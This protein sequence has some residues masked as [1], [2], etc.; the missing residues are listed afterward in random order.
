VDLVGVKWASAGVIILAII[1]SA[2]VNG[3][4]FSNA[5]SHIAS[6]TISLFGF[7]QAQ[8]MLGLCAVPLPPV[9]KSWT[10]DF[11]WSMGIINVGFIENIL[12][13]YQRSTGGTASTLLDSLHTVSVQ[14]EKR[15]VPLVDSAV[16][17]M[18]RSVGAL[19][20]R[21]IQT[22]YGSYIVYGIQRVAFRAG[23]ETTNLFLTGLTFFYIFM[24][25]GALGVVLFKGFC[26]LAVKTKMMKSDTFAEFRAGWFTV[27]KGMSSWQSRVPSFWV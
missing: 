18:R 3:L 16:G 15:S 5:A 6:N 13:W 17:I 21:A 12:T 11:Q 7:F 19:S 25:F 24:L 23:I 14:V 2:I 9:A 27:L 1:S 4:G 20:K 22:S 26:E 8:A 10:Q